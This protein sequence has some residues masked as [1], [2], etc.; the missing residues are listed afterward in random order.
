MIK[1]QFE[2]YRDPNR[3]RMLLK[4]SHVVS[5]DLRVARPKTW[6]YTQ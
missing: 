6:L 3:S 4:F 2:A 1:G 5:A